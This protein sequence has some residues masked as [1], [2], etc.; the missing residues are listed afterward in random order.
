MNN[1]THG[2]LRAKWI[3][4]VSH[5]HFSCKTRGAAILLEKV[6]P[7]Y[8]KTVD[9]KEGH[10]IIVSGEIHNIFLTLINIY[11]PN[12]GNPIF[13]GKSLSLT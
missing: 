9:D 3:A 12:I 2:R 8:R 1:G 7:F 4:E 11:A 6:R 10:Y 5:S 13:L